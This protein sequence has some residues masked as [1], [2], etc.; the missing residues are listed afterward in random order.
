MSQ[1]RGTSDIEALDC[2]CSLGPYTWK[3]TRRQ[4]DAWERAWRSTLARASKLI[5]AAERVQADLISFESVPGDRLRVVRD[6]QYLVPATDE[7]KDWSVKTAIRNHGVVVCSA[8]S[9]RSLEE[10]QERLQEVVFWI[11]VEH[12]DEWPQERPL[13]I[14]YNDQLKAVAGRVLK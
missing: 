10:I 2:E 1:K 7:Y 8:G 6:Q 13:H 11:I 4:K 3:C 12:P 9:Q 5:A 14:S